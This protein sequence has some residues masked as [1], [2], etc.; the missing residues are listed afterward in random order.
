MVT[1]EEAT[2]AR[3]HNS[4]KGIYASS[5][6]PNGWTL[7]GVDKGSPA[8]SSYGK[9]QGYNS[10]ISE[11]AAFAYTTALNHLL[12]DREH[13]YRMGDATAVSYTHLDV[14][15]RQ[16]HYMPPITH[17]GMCTCWRRPPKRAMMSGAG[18]LP[19]WK[20]GSS[21]SPRRS[22]RAWCSAAALMRRVP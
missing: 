14:Y 21:V 10:P 2:I 20:D 1:G 12:A 3:I 8:F 19:D 11:Y 13:V 9:E 7:V 22:W 16:I 15:K 6:S 17:F 18:P 4:V 5:L